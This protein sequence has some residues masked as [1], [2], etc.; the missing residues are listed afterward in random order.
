MLYQPRVATPDLEKAKLMQ[1]MLGWVSRRERQP[2]SLAGSLLLEDGRS[3]DVMITD[4]SVEGCQINSAHNLPIGE[5]VTLQCA[6]QVLKANVRW[7]LLGRAG[8]RFCADE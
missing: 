2:A 1:R 8:L 7:A 3:I 5:T 4:S 6:A